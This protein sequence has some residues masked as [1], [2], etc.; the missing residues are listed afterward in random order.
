MVIEK[1]QQ[2]GYN[3]S[4]A[5]SMSM[6]HLEI[7]ELGSPKGAGATLNQKGLRQMVPTD[8]IKKDNSQVNFEHKLGA[9]PMVDK[10]QKDD[11]KVMKEAADIASKLLEKAEKNIEIKNKQKEEIK[12]EN[13]A[14][15]DIA[16][17]LLEKAEKNI[18]Q[19]N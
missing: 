8:H 1:L 15:K 9:S 6:S 10:N 3:D 17:K 14:A 18:E 4:F 7:P 12:N 16:S 5:Q 2:T 11:G 19:R 13:K